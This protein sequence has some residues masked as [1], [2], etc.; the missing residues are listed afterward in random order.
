MPNKTLQ[1]RVSDKSYHLFTELYEKKR[2]QNLN[3]TKK[4]LMDDIIKK[5]YIHEF[6]LDE[7]DI[8]IY[9]AINEQQH[10]L[11]KTYEYVTLLVKGC[12]TLPINAKEMN[13]Y[14]VKPSRFENLI[15]E[16]INKK[17]EENK[18]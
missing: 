16:K 13:N 1:V 5:A 12:N 9:K 11:N 6:N 4:D 14:V 7:S 3:F 8:D 2:A 10:L 15:N 18:D 17:N